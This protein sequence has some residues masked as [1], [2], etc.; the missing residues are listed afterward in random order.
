MKTSFIIAVI[1]AFGTSSILAAP[2]ADD[3]V[4]DVVP[5]T[6]IVKRS[7]LPGLNAVQTRN[8]RA[9]IAEVKKEK[10]GLHGCEAGIATGLTEVCLPIPNPSHQNHWANWPNSLPS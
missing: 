3:F 2:L 6:E 1:A 8:A 10:L 5:E 9:I 4:E 7:N